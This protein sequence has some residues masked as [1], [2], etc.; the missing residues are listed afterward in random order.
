MTKNERIRDTSR[1]SYHSLPN[2]GT[3]QLEVYEAIKSAPDS[4]DSEL[5]HLLCWTD[6]YKLS[7]RRFELLDQGL[8][9]DSGKRKCDVTGKLCHTW[10]A[11]Q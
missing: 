5:V 11:K 2:Q 3:I 9:V 6:K 4:T 8:I 10:R 7:R 1:L